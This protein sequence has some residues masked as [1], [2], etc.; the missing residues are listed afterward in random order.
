MIRKLLN[1]L[2]RQGA[3]RYIPKDSEIELA[4]AL[5]DWKHKQ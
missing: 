3:L 2:Y 1:A 5:Y 4:N